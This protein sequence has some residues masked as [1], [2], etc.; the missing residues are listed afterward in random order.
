[1]GDSL[2]LSLKLI[3]AGILVINIIPLGAKTSMLIEDTY[4]ESIIDF[5]DKLD[6]NYQEIIDDA[7][8]NKEYKPKS[9]NLLD[10]MQY[11]ATKFLD[12]VNSVNNTINYAGDYIKSI[13]ERLKNALNN[14]LDATSVVSCNLCSTNIGVMF[15]FVVVFNTIFS[16]NIDMKRNFNTLNLNIKNLYLK[17]NKINKFIS[18][19]QSFRNGWWL[20]DIKW[21]WSCIN[22]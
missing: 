1:M 17:E 21:Y 19:S 4:Q 13:P 15:A 9:V 18:L 8:N 16:L 12:L 5:S 22:Y 2:E 7:N 14:V 6:S 3:L 10:N 11:V 20:L